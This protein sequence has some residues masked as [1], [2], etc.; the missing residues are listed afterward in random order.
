MLFF[1]V[2][3]LM[4]APEVNCYVRLWCVPVCGWRNFIGFYVRVGIRKAK[5]GVDAC[6]PLISFGCDNIYNSVFKCLD[7]KLQEML[8]TCSYIGCIYGS[9][10]QGFCFSLR[11]AWKPKSQPT[12]R[13]VW[14]CAVELV[15]TLFFFCL[16]GNSV[17]RNY[18]VCVSM[19]AANE[20]ILTAL[21]FFS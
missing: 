4:S 10:C 20:S 9:V 7:M 17:G 15:R 8:H 6:I 14:T 5:P 11:F 18:K 13:R 1:G 3:R 2:R 19:T 21:L 12:K 16:L